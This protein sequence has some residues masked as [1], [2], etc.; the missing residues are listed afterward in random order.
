M[1][2]FLVSE[3]DSG[4]NDSAGEDDY[5]DDD[6]VSWKVG[7][8]NQ[9]LIIDRTNKL[10]IKPTSIAYHPI[11]S[12]CQIRSVADKCLESLLINRR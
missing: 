11:Q 6:D 2:R 7:A 3:C 1:N 5:S 9:S 12:I 8:I 10:S 4:D